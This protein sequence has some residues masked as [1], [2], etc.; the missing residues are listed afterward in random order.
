MHL[1]PVTD[2]GI[3]RSELGDLS[4]R[5]K[6]LKKNEDDQYYSMGSKC[7][8]DEAYSLLETEEGLKGKKFKAYERD[9]TGKNVYFEDS[10]KVPIYPFRNKDGNIVFRYLGANETPSLE[11]GNDIEDRQLTVFGKA[12]PGQSRQTDG[13]EFVE[14]HKAENLDT[15]FVDVDDNGALLPSGADGVY[16]IY[17]LEYIHH[18]DKE[19]SPEFVYE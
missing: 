18:L 8:I 12:N 14:E 16:R 13:W 10:H 5:I 1:E 9:L 7:R 19:E 15:D 11:T 17:V 6:V 2:F 4:C 3:I